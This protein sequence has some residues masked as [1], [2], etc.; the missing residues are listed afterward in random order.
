MELSMK[1]K[2]LKEYFLKNIPSNKF[3]TLRYVKS[4]SEYISVR[5]NVLDPI[6][7]TLDQGAI[8]TVVDGTGMG[9]AATCNLTDDGIKKAINNAEKWAEFNKKFSLI[10]YSKIEENHPVGEYN[11]IVGTP[12]ES[13]PLP[14]KIDYLKSMNQSLKTNDNIVDWKAALGYIKKESVSFTSNDGEI[15]QSFDFIIPNMNV[16]ASKDSVVQKRSLDSFATAMQG[17][18]EIFDKVKFNQENASRLANEALELL[19]APNCP[20]GKMDLVLDP[21]QMALQ[22]H[23]SIGHPLELDRILGDERNYAGT[24][25]VKQEMFGNF[26]YGSE[27]LN[28]TFDPTVEG[29][30]ATYSF[31]DDG[32]KAEKVFLI[33]KGTLKNALGSNISQAR[34]GIPGVSNSR[35]TNWNRS[36]IDRMANLNL[37]PGDSSFDE[38]IGAIEK[39]IF[40]KTNLSWSI[41]DSRNKFQFGCESGQMIENGKLT[42]LVRNPNYRGIS[43]KFWRNLKMVG[44]LDTF[45]IK[46]LPNCGKGEPNQAIFVGHASPVCLFSDVDVF[47]G[48]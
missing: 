40:M 17:G 39:G 23:E 26:Q 25:F 10:D 18:L 6:E 20:S 9:Y 5:Q 32:N 22:I 19:S 36:P 35:A 33:E 4:N 43:S 41:D 31:D 14:S 45:E 34:S 28:I 24:S 38:M 8:V 15:Y 46:G 42:G 2:N 48:E 13:T 16:I 21:G 27:H 37:E 1:L 7:L 29:Q 11:S 44:N 12:W 3:C 30:F 47:G